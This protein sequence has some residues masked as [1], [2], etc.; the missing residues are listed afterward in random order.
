MET[1]SP[2][3]RELSS[4]PP[5][6]DDYRPPLLS[7]AQTEAPQYPQQ[8]IFA[9]PKLHEYLPPLFGSRTVPQ[10][11]TQTVDHHNPIGSSPY[12]QYENQ[13]VSS[14]NP[15]QSITQLPVNYHGLLT[16]DSV[17]NVFDDVLAHHPNHDVQQGEDYKEWYAM[18]QGRRKGIT[19]A[20]YVFSRNQGQINIDTGDLTHNGHYFHKTDIGNTESE[21]QTLFHEDVNHLRSY[22]NVVQPTTVPCVGASKFFLEECVVAK[23]NKW[24]DIADVS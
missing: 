15:S 5:R 24:R 16:G 20:P 1:V 21:Y 19:S 11:A 10:V 18:E 13:A 2:T 3:D 23:S 4:L 12:D 22:R 7:Q 9:P 8:S 6:F 14:Y 17:Q